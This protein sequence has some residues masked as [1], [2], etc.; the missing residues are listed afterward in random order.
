MLHV[1]SGVQ[2]NHTQVYAGSRTQPL[3]VLAPYHDLAVVN[4]AGTEDIDDLL[5]MNALQGIHFVEG[6]S[7]RIALLCHNSTEC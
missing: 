5:P 6:H 3:T 4:P 1:P 7:H 2:R